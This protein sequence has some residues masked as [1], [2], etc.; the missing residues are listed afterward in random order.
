MLCGSSSVLMP[1][2]TYKKAKAFA[3]N[4]K[5]LSSTILILID[6]E[7]SE[8][9]IPGIIGRRSVAFCYTN[10]VPKNTILP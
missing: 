3:G 7:K 8:T 6:L 4:Y 1:H 5:H 2:A 10:L 9:H